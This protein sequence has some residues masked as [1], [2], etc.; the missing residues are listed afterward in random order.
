M[1]KVQ[2]E[3]NDKDLELSAQATIKK[4]KKEISTLQSK[5]NKLQNQLV[6]LHKDID[7]QKIINNRYYSS[8]Q[9]L[10]MLK[11]TLAEIGET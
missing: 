8:Y 10:L 9:S 4:L 1:P 2:I 7:F 5:N 11:S 6:D 3:I